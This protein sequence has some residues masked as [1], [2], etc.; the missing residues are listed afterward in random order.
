MKKEIFL[1]P[2]PKQINSEKT[3]SPKKRFSLRSRV[4]AYFSIQLGKDI[5]GGSKAFFRFNYKHTDLGN[6]ILTCFAETKISQT[7]QISEQF[8]NEIIERV[9]EKE[10]L[11][12]VKKHTVKYSLK[13]IRF[14]NV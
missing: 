4:L 13:I 3:F 1:L 7:S 10:V 12:K 8:L 5:Q 14:R 2:A 9:Q 11:E 6:K